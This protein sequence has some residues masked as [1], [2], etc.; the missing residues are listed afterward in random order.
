MPHL[1]RDGYSCVRLF[2]FLPPLFSKGSRD[3]LACCPRCSSCGVTADQ[4]GVRPYLA[5]APAGYGLV[6]VRGRSALSCQRIAAGSPVPG[7]IIELCRG[8]LWAKARILTEPI[9]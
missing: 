6:L 8:G 1:C 7:L 4:P 2:Y 9:Y 5:P 3:A